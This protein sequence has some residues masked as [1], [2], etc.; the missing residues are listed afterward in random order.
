MGKCEVQAVGAIG[1]PSIY[2]EDLA[3][4]ICDRLMAGESMRQICADDGM[5][6]RVTVMRWQDSNEAFAAKCARARESQADLMDDKILDVAERVER[7][8]LDPNAAR[9]AISAYQWRASKLK[10]K[11]YGDSVLNKHADADGES[12]KSG[13]VL[14]VTANAPPK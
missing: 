9:V 4:N 5:P 11:K 14:F 7:C 8:E 3:D 2:S 10:P 6:H 1:R 12:L 13:T